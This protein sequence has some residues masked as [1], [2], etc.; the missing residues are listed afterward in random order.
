MLGQGP[1]QSWSQTVTTT[2]KRTSITCIARSNVFA[3]QSL[4]RLLEGALCVKLAAMPM[5]MPEQCYRNV[6][7]RRLAFRIAIAQIPQCLPSILIA[8]SV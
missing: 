6:G 4:G 3:Y 5:P 2:G 1:T 8:Y 7:G